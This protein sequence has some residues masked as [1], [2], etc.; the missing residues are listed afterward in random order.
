MDPIIINL[1][2]VVIGTGIAA[3]TDYKSSIIPDKLS[4]FMIAS[5]IILAPIVHN[6]LLFIYSVAAIVFGIGFA[7]YSFGQI[8]GGDVK[9]FTAIALLVPYY[10]D[11]MKPIAESIGINPAIPVYPFVGSV[12]I[13]SGII[14]PMFAISIQ[15]HYKIFKKKN[16]IEEYSRKIKKGLLF[17]ALLTP[18]LLI[19]IYMSIA[20]LFLFIPMAITVSLIPFKEDMIDL[21]YS[22]KK[23]IKDLNDDDVLALEQISEEKQEELG[24][25]RKTFTSPELKNIKKKAEESNYE[26]VPVCEDLPIFVPYIFLALLISLVIGDAFLYLVRVTI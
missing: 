12:F 23:P 8:G 6:N 13:L 26:K 3:Y 2:I 11:I 10:P 7:M 18:L 17:A 14:G 22:V 19:W 9:L 24:L 16:E 4:H 25:W 15:N 20:F 5:G 21:F 1:L